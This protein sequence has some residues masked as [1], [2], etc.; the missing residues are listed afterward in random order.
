VNINI[1]KDVTEEYAQ[2]YN[3]IRD[4]YADRRQLRLLA[5]VAFGALITA[6]IQYKQPFLFPLLI[7][8]LGILWYQD[9]RYRDSIYKRKAYIQV[10][11]EQNCNISWE[12]TD[13]EAKKMPVENKQDLDK[14]VK[15]HFKLRVTPKM[16]KFLEFCHFH[17][18]TALRF[19]NILL[20]VAWITS[21]VALP[22]LKHRPSGAYIIIYYVLWIF[23]GLC[24]RELLL[25]AGDQ[26]NA[27][28]KWV[29]YWEKFKKKI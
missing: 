3:S 15:E 22:F 10:F 13:F 26:E 18:R 24:Y 14:Q 5:M 27:K 21:A 23:L 8:I 1:S 20:F 17:P 28:V 16:S 9:I 2:L 6:G 7:I 12:I 11:L 29:N 4:L 19:F 25:W